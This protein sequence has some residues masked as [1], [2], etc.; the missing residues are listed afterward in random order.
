[1]GPRTSYPRGVSVPPSLTLTVFLE[2]AHLGRATA[3][4]VVQRVQDDAPNALVVLPHG[5][6]HPLV[7]AIGTWLG[8]GV[9]AVLALPVPGDLTGLAGPAP[10]N[11]AALD[12]GEAVLLPRLGLGLVPTDDAR[13][14]VWQGYDAAAPPYLDP[15][16]ASRALRLALLAAT[17]RLVDLDVARWQPEIP[18]LL[19]NLHHRQA[20]ALPRHWDGRRVETVERALLCR[21]IVELALQDEG[22]A[23]SAHEMEQR[24]GALR[25]LDA[26]SRRA[27]VAACSDSLGLP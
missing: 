10:L 8:E 1:M 5:G 15:G 24:R 3:T 23:V 16:E 7:D 27:L 22:G 9:R 17:Q 12:A 14:Q 18:D 4:D 25:D 6:V 19:L 21:R 11:Q 13:T 2:A 20:T 26:A